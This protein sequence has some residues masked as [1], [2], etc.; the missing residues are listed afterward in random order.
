LLVFFLVFFLLFS[1]AL[2]CALCW[3]HQ[4]PA[5]SRAAAKMRVLP[6]SAV[7][8]SD[9]VPNRLTGHGDSPYDQET[10]PAPISSSEDRYFRSGVRVL[11]HGL[12]PPLGFRC[13]GVCAGSLFGP[14][15]LAI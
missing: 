13:F 14:P 6:H 1:L 8:N 11:A 3:P 5:Q 15:V 10:I 4:G 9:V 2:L 12:P 7:D